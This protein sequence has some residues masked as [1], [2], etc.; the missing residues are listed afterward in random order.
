MSART[1][2]V[3]SLATVLSAAAWA[4]PPPEAPAVQV[5]GPP[6]R[7]EAC[8]WVVAADAQSRLTSASRPAHVHLAT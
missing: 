3:A 6:G 8:Y 4:L 5:Q 1:A 2:C 7:A